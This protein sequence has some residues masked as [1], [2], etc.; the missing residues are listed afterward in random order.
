MDGG[1]LDHPAT[2]ENLGMLAQRGAQIAGPA[3]GHLASGLSGK[4]RMLEASELIGHIRL[5][6]GR[7]VRSR[8][9]R[10]VVSAGGTQEPS[11]RSG[12]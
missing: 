12:S 8:G 11:I 3:E 6:M 10:V 4:G 7:E 9:K 2:Q 5:I 1:M